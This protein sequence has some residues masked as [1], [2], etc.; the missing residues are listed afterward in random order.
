LTVPAPLWRPALAGAAATCAG[1]GLARFAFVPLFPALVTAG[2][3]D[4][5][6]AGL[7]GAGSLA[8]YLLGALAAPAIGQRFGTPQ[9]LIAAMVLVVLSFLASAIPGG[10]W[11]LMPWRLLAG[12]AG[13]LLMALAGPSVQAVV[14][15]GRRGAAAGIVVAGV[16]SGIVLGAVIL[17]A[18]LPWG[19]PAAGWLGLAAATLA[20]LAFAAP[21]FPAA[22]PPPPPR[23]V[24]RRA[25]LLAA[26]ALSGA[27][28]VPPMVYLADLAARGLG[29]GVTAGS[30]IWGV[31]G[32]GGVAG[33]LLGGRAAD[34]LGGARAVRWWLVI[35]GLALALC[36]APWPVALPLAAAMGGFAGVGVS[37]VTLS[38]ARESGGGAALWARAT[39]AY[40]AAQALAAFALAALFGATGESHAAV[41]GAG[42]ALSLAALAMTAAGERQS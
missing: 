26:Y 41:F 36:L 10:L 42:L 33:T 37:A 18:L 28:M 23:K 29:L 24:E 19:G 8:G 27:G 7:L 31:F 17:P 34:R 20:L 30:L 14:D 2:W 16:G 22:R 11:W 1:I 15:P 13:A 32:L 6:E 38:W 5:T 3:V 12:I 21:R 9:V 4:G 40:A 39:A 25:R 35:Q